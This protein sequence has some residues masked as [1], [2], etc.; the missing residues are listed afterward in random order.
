MKIAVTGATGF[1]GTNLIPYLKISNHNVLEFSRSDSL[2]WVNKQ[3]NI[4]NNNSI[5]VLIHLAGKAHD[6]KNVTKPEEYYQA[7]TELTKQVYDTFLFSNAK[8]FISL[9]SVKA[10]ADE[11]DSVLTEDSKPN[12]LTHYGKSKFLAEQYIMS[13]EIPNGKKIFILRPCMIHGKGNKGNLNLLYKLVSKGIPW[14]LGKFNNQR[15]FCNIDNLMFVIKEFI[16]RN[17]IPSGIYNIADDETLS[18]NEIIS[19]LSESLDKKTIIWNLPKWVIKRIAEFGDII[20]LPLNSERLNKLTQN[21]VV[22]NHKLTLA[23]GKKMPI[24]AR[25]GL[26]NTLKHF[27]K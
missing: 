8:I 18:T 2:F 20:N 9:S 12:P 1:V 4:L 13:K 10:V 25:E 24:K 22:S 21:Y 5:D 23:I 26:I 14:P 6:L 27:S 3:T 17:D 7:N 15:S 16:E 19:I 11:V